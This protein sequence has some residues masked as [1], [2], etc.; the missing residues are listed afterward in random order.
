MNITAVIALINVASDA[1]SRVIAGIL[2]NS[3]L[4]ADEIRANRDK[5]SADTHSI[6][7][8]ELAKLG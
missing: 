7:E 5:L 2:S 3:G 8:Q 4:T 6:V 1:F